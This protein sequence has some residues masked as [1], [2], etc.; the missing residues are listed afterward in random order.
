MRAGIDLDKGQA[1]M[2]VA[3]PRAAGLWPPEGGRDR[4]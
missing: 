3:R 2:P 1:F 4:R